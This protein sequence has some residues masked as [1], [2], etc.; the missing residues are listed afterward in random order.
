M[1]Q[2]ILCILAILLSGCT[3]SPQYPPIEKPQ[4]SKSYIQA[5][6][7]KT[8]CLLPSPDVIDASTSGSIELELEISENGDPLNVGTIKSSGRA[9][10]DIAFQKSAMACRFN[11]A[12]SYTP[13]TG[14]TKPVP[15]KYILKQ[16]WPAGREFFGH[17]RCF[18]VDYPRRAL[19]HQE[20]AEVH[21]YFRRTP[22]ENAFEFKVVSSR[23]SQELTQLSLAATESCLAHKEAQAGLLAGKWYVA[24]IIWRIE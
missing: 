4:K 3:Q 8:G 13:F 22:P 23:E 1:H 9:S 5:A 15:S 10:L 11:P 24:P 14:K 6:S 20:Q 7:I 2:S 19:R 17:F 16:S 21:I 12:T 18:Q